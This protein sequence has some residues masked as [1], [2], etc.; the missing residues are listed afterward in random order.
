MSKVQQWR[1]AKSKASEATKFLALL[2]KPQN[3]TARGNGYLHG[4][5]VV[6]S[7]YHQETDGAKNYHE[8]KNFD[9]ALT[10]VIKERFA[11][12]SKMAVDAMHEN[13]RCA[14]IDAQTEVQAMLAEI[15]KAQ[16]IK[17]E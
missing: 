15:D 2:G 12:L 7:I 13:A 14:A 17:G 3:T 10:K 16:E 1:D 8:C 5:S 11:E 4:I 6:T 9:D